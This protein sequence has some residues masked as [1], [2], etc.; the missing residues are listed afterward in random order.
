MIDGLSTIFRSV[1]KD[2]QKLM[3][4][5][6]DSLSHAQDLDT[7]EKIAASME[8]LK[9]DAQSLTDTLSMVKLEEEKLV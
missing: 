5:L 8:R 6:E 9:T 4:S 7:K 2:H 3:A 1:T